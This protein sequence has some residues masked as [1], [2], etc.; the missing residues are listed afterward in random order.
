M[1]NK[2]EKEIRKNLTRDEKKLRYGLYRENK[3]KKQAWRD[4]LKTPKGIEVAKKRLSA[5]N[6]TQRRLKEYGLNIKDLNPFK[7]FHSK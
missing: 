6:I 2:K 4:F 7:Y 3:V 5:R 1:I